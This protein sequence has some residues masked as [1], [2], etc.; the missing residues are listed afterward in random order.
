MT[1]GGI[2]THFS[3]KFENVFLRHFHLWGG[4]SAQPGGPRE[5]IYCTEIAPIKNQA[6]RLFLEENSVFCIV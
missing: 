1:F 5:L 2:S 3:Q 6:L 4:A